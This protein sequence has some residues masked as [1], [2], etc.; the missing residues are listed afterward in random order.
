MKD[1]FAWLGQTKNELAGIIFGVPVVALALTAGVGTIVAICSG[2]LWHAL[3]LWIAV[4]A[5][6]LWWLYR[7]ET[8]RKNK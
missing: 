1:F 8:E 3:F 4:P 6:A 7:D 5:A 2:W